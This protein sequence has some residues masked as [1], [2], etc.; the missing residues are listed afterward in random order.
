[1]LEDRHRKN[2]VQRMWLDV[3][4]PR[5]EISAD[6][7]NIWKLLAEKFVIGRPFAKSVVGS[8]RRPLT[9]GSPPPNSR[10]RPAEG[11]WPRTA[12]NAQGR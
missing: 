3:R 10:T 5:S 11:T 12:L 7:F 6:N 9:I 4:G 1:M 2:R 8:A